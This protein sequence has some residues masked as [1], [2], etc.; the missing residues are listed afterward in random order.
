MSDGGVS[1]TFAEFGKTLMSLEKRNDPADT[2]FS[3]RESHIL[4]ICSISSSSSSIVSGLVAIYM[5]GAIDYKKRVFRHQLIMFLIFFDLVKLAV[6][7][8]YPSRIQTKYLAYYNHNFCEIVGFFTSV[9][10]EGADI[11]ILSFAIHTGLLIFSPNAKVKNGN[12]FEGGLFKY[13]FYVYLISFLTPCVLLSLAFIDGSGYKPLTTWC[14]LPQEPRWYRLVLS[15]IPRYLIVI[16]IVSIYVS[17]YYYVTKQYSKVGGN[18]RE[19]HN[20]PEEVLDETFFRK[21]ITYLKKLYKTF[22]KITMAILFPEMTMYPFYDTEGADDTKRIRMTDLDENGELIPTPSPETQN[23]PTVATKQDKFQ[24]KL[25]RETYHQFQIRR[26]QIQKQMKSIFIYPISYVFLWSFPFILQCFEFNNAASNI[27]WLN[28]VLAFFQPF[29]CT[30]D[31]MVFLYRERPWTITTMKTDT[32]PQDNYEYP[33]WRQR[34]SWLPLYGLPTAESKQKTLYD[35]VRKQLEKLKLRSASNS[36][37]SSPGDDNK[38][39]FSNI[40][41]GSD[42]DFVKP[43]QSA[44]TKPPVSPSDLKSNQSENTKPIVR[45]Q[46]SGVDPMEPGNQHVAPDSKRRRSSK[47]S[48]L[49]ALSVGDGR[50][51]SGNLSISSTQQQQQQPRKKSNQSISDI[52][53]ATSVSPASQIF[54]QAYAIN[55]FHFENN[56]NNLSEIEELP[57]ASSKTLQ[58]QQSPTSPMSVTFKENHGSPSRISSS[59]SISQQLNH[60]NPQQARNFS[61]AFGLTRRP[62][63]FDVAHNDKKKNPFSD[64]NMIHHGLGTGSNDADKSG[65][66]QEDQEEDD[67]DLDFMDFL[68]K[69][70]PV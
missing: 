58:P 70:P 15:W 56:N 37:E 65:N 48:W 69:G 46:G 5:F 2:R 55:N 19:I 30:V 9:A 3:N 42:M 59:T 27:V 35:N 11:A 29:N 34:L 38:H 51:S 1:Q 45:R 18:F 7:L 4:R 61:N 40:L 31:T 44:V 22:K 60:S 62:S 26:L 14:Y 23:E 63:F 6:L 68:K 52:N 13:R 16:T 36:S 39:D 10:I 54:P 33:I 17:I 66:L 41:A 12:N 8:I 28:A 50:R 67:D 25:H 53:D 20:T 57:S 32:A 21:C 64:D 24:E 43:P 47:L 49:S